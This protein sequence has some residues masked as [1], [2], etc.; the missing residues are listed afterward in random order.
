MD[1]RLATHAD[2][3]ELDR[4]FACARDTMRASGNPSQWWPGYPERELL[5][6]DIDRGQLYA[7][8][9]EGRI[10]GAFVYALG[11]DPTYAVIEQGEWLDDEPYGTIH[12]IASDGTCRGLFGEILAYCRGVQPNVRVDTHVDN[13]IMRH[14]VEKAGFVYCGII[15]IEDGSPRLAYQLPAGRR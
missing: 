8:E 7:V 2:L 1:I 14:L 5:L 15:H 13:A 4:V 12:R 11:D 9:H 10:C 6:D 3:D